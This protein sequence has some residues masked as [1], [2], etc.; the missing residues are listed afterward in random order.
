MQFYRDPYAD[1]NTTYYMVWVYSPMMEDHTPMT[2]SRLSLAKSTDG[3][4]WEFL[5]D[6]WRWEHRGCVDAH[7]SHVVDAFVKTNKD[8]VICGAGYS[9]HLKVEGEGGSEYHHAQ[10]QH[11]YSIKKSDLKPTELKPV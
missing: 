1:N 5:G 6:V 3:K 4:T 11:L 7:I 9:E 10:R 2:R 8:Y